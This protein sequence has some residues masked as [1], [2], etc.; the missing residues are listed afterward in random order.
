[1]ASSHN[2][3]CGVCSIVWKESCKQT[4]TGNMPKSPRQLLP[5]LLRTDTGRVRINICSALYSTKQIFEFR[6]INT[7]PGVFDLFYFTWKSFLQI[8][9]SRNYLLLH[10]LFSKHFKKRYYKY[11]FHNPSPLL[12]Q[13]EYKV[14]I[15]WDFENLNMLHCLL[16][17]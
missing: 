10:S 9:V 12:V 6:S 4:V 11:S 3:S 14:L 16:Q 17:M 2:V 5:R 1:M 7:C 15:I 8:P 13:V